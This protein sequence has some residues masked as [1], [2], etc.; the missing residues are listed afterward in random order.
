MAQ[1]FYARLAGTTVALHGHDGPFRLCRYCGADRGYVGP[2]TGP[3]AAALICG[4]CTRH[5]AWI[6][7]D[8]LAAMAARADAGRGAA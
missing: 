8:H 7:R 4:N 1:S 5:L 3:H 2:G 6:S